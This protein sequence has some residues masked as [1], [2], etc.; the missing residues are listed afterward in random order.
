MENRKRKVLYD[1]KGFSLVEVLVV[2]TIMIILV[3]VAALSFSIVSNA[4]VSKAAN[5]LNSTFATARSTCMAKGVDEGT[6][7]LKIIEGKLYAYIGSEAEGHAATKS[8][9]QQISSNG[10]TIT[11]GNASNAVGGLLLSDGYEVKYQFSPSGSLIGATSSDACVA[12]LFMN[13]KR[14]ASMFFYPETG[15]HDVGIWNP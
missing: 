14:G 4:N 10:M 6:L 9:M 13:K 8:E 11:L 12:Y 15:R 2:I 1:N 5:S 3:G 7:T